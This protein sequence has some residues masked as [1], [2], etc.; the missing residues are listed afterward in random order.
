MI[1]H[2]WEA[3]AHLE[4]EV[5]EVDDAGREVWLVTVCLCDGGEMSDDLGAAAT[6]APVVAH[7]RPDEARDLASE[8]L[9]LAELAEHHNTGGA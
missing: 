3:H 4:D 7:L 8:L 9:K 5:R 6:R 2:R 1:E